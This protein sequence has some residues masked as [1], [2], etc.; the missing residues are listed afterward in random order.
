MPTCRCSW[1]PDCEADWLAQP[2]KQILVA[3]DGSRLAEEILEQ[4]AALLARALGAEMLLVRA[5]SST[6]HARTL[7]GR[8]VLA[9]GGFSEIDDAW[10]YLTDHADRLLERG[11][12]ASVWVVTGTA[13]ATITAAARAERMDLIAMT[14]H[15][16]GG[17][18]R[19][20]V[21]S[22]ADG[23]LRRSPVPIM[24]VRSGIADRADA[25]T[26]TGGRDDLRPRRHARSDE[27][28]IPADGRGWASAR[29]RRRDCT[30][31]GSLLSTAPVPVVAPRAVQPGS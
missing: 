28:D 11:I 6:L 23:V 18:G 8:F 26:R 17:L 25:G 3:L 20:L 31:T 13:A 7:G 24:L 30:C 12:R 2:P 27:C 16:R 22:I 19:L 29:N 5:L 10:H 1:S 15:G 4:T 21:G 9:S 14:T